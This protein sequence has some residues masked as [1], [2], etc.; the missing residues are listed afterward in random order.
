VISIAVMEEHRGKGIGR[1]L[2]EG[3][4]E[5]VKASGAS[6]MYLEVRVS[7]NP[8]IELY[9]KL[10]FNKVKTSE[11]YYRDGENAFIMVKDFHKS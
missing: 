6:E 7:N 3:G 4:I 9:I 1:A 5:G 8:A 11:G 2:M 10:G